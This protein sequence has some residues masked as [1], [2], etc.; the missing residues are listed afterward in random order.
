MQE[1]STENDS[2]TCVE[3]LKLSQEKLKFSINFKESFSQ[4]EA[5]KV[6]LLY[7]STFKK[8]QFDE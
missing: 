4:S 2:I 3:F 6:L 8:M 7:P 5:W 1:H